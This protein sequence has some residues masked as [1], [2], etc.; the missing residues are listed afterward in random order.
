MKK[1]SGILLVCLLAGCAGT[2]FGCVGSRPLAMGGAFIGLSDDANATYWNPAGLAQMA[3]EERTGAWTHTSTNRDQINYQ[4]F[5]S[6]AAC[7]ELPK[8]GKMAFGA[9]YVKDDIGLALNGKM[10]PDTQNWVWG[11]LAVDAGKL[12]MFGV[13]VRKIDDS[14]P[15]YSV[16]TGLGF[17]VGYLYR[18]DDQFSMGLLIQDINEP[19][20]R[21]AGVGP[22]NRIRN[23]RAG[24]AFR[25][26]NDIVL[27]VDGYDLADNGNA[28]SAR[29][30]LEKTFG[31]LAL[32]AGYYGLGGN[33]SSG[34]TFGIG[35]ES[36]AVTFD[37]TVLT[38][39]FDNTVM[40]S[41]TYKAF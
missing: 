34:A 27:T 32:R 9:S 22:T 30:G 14:V 7:S 2:A 29:F 13:N 20:M 31:R 25:P 35:V 8:L 4:E 10:V 38:G 26:R 19:E 41:S 40:I 36:H 24:L 21:I 17:D 28:R 16:K 3:L 11:S 39:D 18:F 15:G 37:A 1:I 33:T 5:G 6:M 12:G 23:W